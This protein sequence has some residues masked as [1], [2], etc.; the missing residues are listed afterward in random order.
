MVQY[1]QGQ[2]TQSSPQYVQTSTPLPPL[3]P[4]HRNPTV[5]LSYYGAVLSCSRLALVGVS[6][7]SRLDLAPMSR[8]VATGLF[9][10]ASHIDPVSIPY[11]H[12]IALVSISSRSRINL[13]STSRIDLGSILYQYFTNR[14][15][16]YCID[17]APAS[18]SY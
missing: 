11:R 8:R 14:V 7:G 18:V 15:S 3:H 10:C 1:D 16:Q 9:P 13:A 17:L 12:H 4:P 2:P 5:A 6:Y